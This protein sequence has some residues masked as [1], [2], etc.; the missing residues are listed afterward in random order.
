MFFAK[1]GNYLL[2]PIWLTLIVSLL[3]PT[4]PVKSTPKDIDELKTFTRSESGSSEA[5]PIDFE[6]A[7]SK[8]PMSFELNQ[9]QVIPEVKFFSRGKDYN[10]FF[11]KAGAIL[12]FD[13]NSKERASLRMHFVG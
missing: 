6:N 7:Y 13:K 2:S 1:K 8:L 9:G 5:K 12:S 4:L 11:T 3:S 10:L